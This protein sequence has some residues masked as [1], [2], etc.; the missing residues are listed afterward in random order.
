MI[1]NALVSMIILPCVSYMQHYKS[2]YYNTWNNV[3][4]HSEPYQVFIGSK[5]GTGKWVEIL[6]ITYKPVY[7]WPKDYRLI[8]ICSVEGIKRPAAV[9]EKSLD[10]IN[11]GI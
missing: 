1:I 7:E 3:S 10:S 9:L 5:N 11:E 2:D 6:L 8:Q 4:T